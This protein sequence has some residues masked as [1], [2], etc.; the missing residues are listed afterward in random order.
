[1][2]ADSRL[3]DSTPEYKTFG[4]VYLKVSAPLPPAVRQGTKSLRGNGERA[5][6]G[7]PQYGEFGEV[8]DFSTIALNEAVNVW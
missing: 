6:Q 8:T 1:M 3:F 4:E 5:K 2:S 7:P